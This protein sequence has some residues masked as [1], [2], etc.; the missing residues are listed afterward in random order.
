[1]SGHVGV[2]EQLGFEIRRG[3]TSMLRL[4]GFHGIP[5]YQLVSLFP[6]QPLANQSQQDGLRIP[7]PH[8]QRQIALHVFRIDDQARRQLRQGG[9]HVIQQRAGIRKNDA[10][11]RA[12]TDVT[13]VPQGD[14][15]H[16]GHRV[17]P[18]H[19]GQTGQA[20]PGDGIP[21]VGHGA[22]ALLP[23]GERLLGLQDLGALQVTE[24]DA[25]VLKGRTHQ[26][27]SVHVFGVQIALDHLGGNR[28][29]AQSELLAHVGLHLRREM[30]M[31]PH[32]AG[33]LAHRDDVAD[34]LQPLQAAAELL[35]H[36]RQLQSK[37]RG[38]A[39]NAMAAADAGRELMLV[40]AASDHREEFLDVGDEQV[41][42]L[43][44]LHGKGGVDDVAAGQ[45]E[46]QPSAGGII[47]LLGDRGGEANDVVIQRLFQFLGTGRQ[48]G[49]VGEAAIG[50]S[51]HP[52]EVRLG[53]HAGLHQRLAGQKFDPE[54]DAQPV[55][56]G[57]DRPH[58]G[59]RIT[60]NHV[61]VRLRGLGIPSRAAD[62][63]RLE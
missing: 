62:G 8:G 43:H 60:L 30:R 35:V 10:L 50:P 6:G 40:G 36:Q 7:H 2:R 29:G 59:T 39:M 58:F 26:R 45:A 38:L 51:L 54:P 22:A 17:A 47:D 49:G 46:V 20:F 52:E 55:L 44:H 18:Q 14:V 11:D 24:L 31:G 41:G 53:N 9:Q 28:R 13:L 57:P 56:V 1:M 33:E 61:P 5:L 15:L 48:G 19:A 42:R 25:P 32:R 3:V 4:P 37:G 27:E 63:A 34:V 23:A 21:L 12:V 16:R